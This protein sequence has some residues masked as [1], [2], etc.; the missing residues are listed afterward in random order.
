MDSSATRDGQALLQ[1]YV[2]MGDVVLQPGDLMKLHEVGFGKWSLRAP[3]G[4]AFKKWAK[5]LTDDQYNTIVEIAGA[6]PR[7]GAEI[8]DASFH[9]KIGVEMVR[10]VVLAW[11]A[12][13]EKVEEDMDIA[14]VVVEDSSTA[15]RKR[16]ESPDPPIERE[17]KC[18]KVETPAAAAE[19]RCP[20]RTP[21]ER[22]QQARC[23]DQVVRMVERLNPPSDSDEITIKEW[24]AMKIANGEKGDLDELIM[25]AWT[26]RREY[27]DGPEPVRNACNASIM[28]LV[29]AVRTG[30][31][32]SGDPCRM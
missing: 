18:R 19:E 28:C 16:S 11:L 5:G 30:E 21:G 20:Y 7:D 13:M 4:G 32:L 23:D 31:R 6:T 12:R 15:T 27:M 2:T 25:A 3:Y 8:P 17:P 10:H 24:C 1:E 14:Q 9:S 29:H 22:V 26:P